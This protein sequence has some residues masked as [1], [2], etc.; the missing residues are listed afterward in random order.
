MLNHNALHLQQ[1]SEL[2]SSFSNNCGGEFCY[3]DMINIRRPTFK[4][5]IPKP[6]RSNTAPYLRKIKRFQVPLCYFFTANFDSIKSVIACTHSDN[7]FWYELLIQT[8]KIDISLIL[9]KLNSLPLSAI[10]DPITPNA[11]TQFFI[12]ISVTSLYRNFNNITCF[13]YDE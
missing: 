3:S 11:L 6:T 1:V 9:S 12:G 2:W 5:L 8:F 4:S 10:K 13:S 7:S